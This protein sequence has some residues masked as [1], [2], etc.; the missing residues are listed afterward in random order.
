LSYQA[1]YGNSA[2]LKPASLEMKEHQSAVRQED[3]DAL[4]ALFS[5]DRNE[6]GLAYE[7]MRAGLV[8]FF[9]F[10][11]C[12]DAIALADETLNRVALKTVGFDRTK[13]VKLT[14]YV[15]GFAVNVHREYVRSPRQREIAIETDEFI[16]RIRETKSD[17]REPMFDCLHDC[18]AKLGSSDRQ[19]FIEYYSRERQ[20]K[21]ELRKQ[22]AERLGCRVEVLHTKVCRLRSSLRTCVTGCV[23]KN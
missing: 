17:D 5:H 22:M 10:R 12:T 23:E 14:S 11:G 4:L 6:A 19:I 2:L 9:E 7:R 3:F 1:E 16:D 8:R 18:L 21:I 15:Y 20:E 13:N